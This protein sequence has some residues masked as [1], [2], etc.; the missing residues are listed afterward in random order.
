MGQERKPSGIIFSMSMA[1]LC[2]GGLDDH[3]MVDVA[4]DT[5]VKI[6]LSEIKDEFESVHQLSSLITEKLITEI[7]TKRFLDFMMEIREKL[8]GVKED[9]EN[10]L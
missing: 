5:P 3:M 7:G 6:D 10:D 8:Y 1:D 2:H 4:K 9:H